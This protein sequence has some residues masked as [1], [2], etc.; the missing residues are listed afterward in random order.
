M[1]P[2]TPIPTFLT[3]TAL[4][5]WLL[6]WFKLLVAFVTITVPRYIYSVLSYSMTL[7]VR[8]TTL[9]SNLSLNSLCIQLGFWNFA[10]L[11]VCGCIALNYWIR[12]KYLNDYMQLKEPPLQKPGGNELHPD[13]N[14][15]ASSALWAYCAFSDFL[16]IRPLLS[17]TTWTTFCKPS[18]S[19]DLYVS[20]CTSSI[21]LH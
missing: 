6:S 14:T 20:N 13:V 18:E 5:V 10:I 19:L 15:G 12:F 7:T 21:S 1:K 8:S 2:V 11:F 3:C 4:S 16:K 9:P 17:I